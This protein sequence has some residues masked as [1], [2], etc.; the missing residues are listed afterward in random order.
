MCRVSIMVRGDY[1]LPDVSRF[2]GVF[3]E[4]QVQQLREDIL[5]TPHISLSSTEIRRQLSQGCM[6]EGAL[7]PAVE[8]Y[9]RRNCL[10]GFNV[11]K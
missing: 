9:I 4:R 10:Y 8:E 2:S 5:Q 6:P 3:S 7:H 1:P 11:D